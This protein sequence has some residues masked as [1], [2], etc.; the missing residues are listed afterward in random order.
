MRRAQGGKRLISL[1]TTMSMA[2][3]SYRGPCSRAHG[4]GL[5]GAPVHERMNEPAD[6]CG[7]RRITGA[8]SVKSAL[9]DIS[10]IPCVCLSGNIRVIKSTT[11]TTRT[12]MPGTY[13]CSK[14]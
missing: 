6:C 8:V 7:R 1:R 11:L 10:S 3:W 4:S 9:N 13:F 12:L 14:P 2:W 5:I